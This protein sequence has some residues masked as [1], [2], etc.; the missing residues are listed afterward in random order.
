MSKLT[1]KE[2][3]LIQSIIDN[4]CPTCKGYIGLMAH[5][6]QWK[7]SNDITMENGIVSFDLAG[8][9]DWT[10][11]PVLIY[12]EGCKTVWLDRREV[13]ANDIKNST[14]SLDDGTVLPK[15]TDSDPWKEHDNYPVKDWQHEVSENN[16]RLGYQ[17]WVKHQREAKIYVCSDCGKDLTVPNSVERE[18]ISKDE[19]PSMFGKGHYDS[20]GNYDPDNSTDLSGGRYD[21]IDGSDTCINCGEVVG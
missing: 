7:I 17:D 1:Q 4:G 8:D 19:G 11:G 3:K 18:Y 20:N 16:T 5:G 13:V 2:I 10:V 6:Y 9:G 12:C 14:V 21:L 15:P